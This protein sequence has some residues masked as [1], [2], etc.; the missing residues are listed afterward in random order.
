MRRTPLLRTPLALFLGLPTAAIFF[1]T[2]CF[3]QMPDIEVEELTAARTS[4]GT[5]D[6]QSSAHPAKGINLNLI[7]HKLALSLAVDTAWQVELGEAVLAS[8]KSETLR[9]MLKT[10]VAEQRAFAQQ[11]ELLTD[12]RARQ[13]IEQAAREI[14]RDAAAGKAQP[15]RFRPLALQRNATAMMVRIRL[16][17]LQAYEDL[18]RA[19]LNAA[20]SAD[21][22]RQ[23]LRHHLQHQM[24]MLAM[25]DVF[26]SQ[27]SADFAAVI[28]NQALVARQHLEGCRRL[29][30][31]LDG[32][33]AASAPAALPVNAVAAP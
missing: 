23:F 5:S 7:D 16:E 4:T 22:D 10:R 26:E 24:Q 29:L 28:A 25:L 18:I 32:R 13:A 30:A 20:D 6:D 14:E 17:I 11:L 8:A 15:I 3:A 2:S 1:S 21:F 19:E 12:G 27:A 31:E 9:E 33:T